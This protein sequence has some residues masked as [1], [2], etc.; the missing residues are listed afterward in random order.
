MIKPASL[1][2]LL[3]CCCPKNHIRVV[4]ALLVSIKVAL[5]T[6][7]WFY[8]DRLFLSLISI[9]RYRKLVWS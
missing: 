9:R 4:P 1:A 3:I 6:I 2:S 5:L 8:F 7:S